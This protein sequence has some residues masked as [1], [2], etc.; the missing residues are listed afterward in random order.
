[1]DGLQ[2]TTP[3]SPMALRHSKANREVASSGLLGSA[4][5]EPLSTAFF[6]G[7]LIDEDSG[8]EVGVWNQ[9]TSWNDAAEE[10]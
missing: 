3:S 5:T 6:G 4:G 1:M 7:M 8:F 10:M 9:L 2:L